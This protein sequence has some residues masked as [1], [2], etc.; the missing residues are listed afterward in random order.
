MHGDDIVTADGTGTRTGVLASYDPFGDPVDAATGNIGTIP[1]DTATPS[2][3][4]VAGNSYGWEGSHQKLDQTA[5]DIATIEMGA[6]QYVP[7]L[8]RFLSVDPVPG[9]NANDYN[10]PCDPI[11]GSDLSGARALYDDG[12]GTPAQAEHGGASAQQVVALRARSAAASRVSAAPALPRYDFGANMRQLSEETGIAGSAVDLLS[13]ASNLVAAA[14]AWAPESTIPE[15]AEA[16][17]LL[18]GYLGWGLGVVSTVTGCIGYGL[19]VTCAYQ[20]TTT[21]LLS[22]FVVVQPGLMGSVVAIP[23]DL[24]FLGW[25]KRS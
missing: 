23:A 18:S 2:N 5:G 16:I 7:L 17:S 14:T 1:A 4:T 15:D 12:T 13:L 19:D 25:S 9:G 22:P 20:V 24:E 8:G 21:L 6:R 3:T 11:N 10:Y